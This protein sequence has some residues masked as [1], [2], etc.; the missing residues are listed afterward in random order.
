VPVD[1]THCSLALSLSEIPSNLVSGFVL[2]SL[3]GVAVICAFLVLPRHG[4]AETGGVDLGV[5]SSL[6]RGQYLQH[7][8]RILRAIR[9]INSAIL[10]ERDAGQL[11][12]RACRSLTEARGYR[13][14][15]VGLVDE[16]GRAMDLVWQVGFGEGYMAEVK[17]TWQDSPTG[18]AVRSGEP[19]VMRDIETAE[20]YRPWRSRALSQGYRSSAALPL[21]SGGRVLGALSV[22]SEIPDAFDIQEVGVLQE[23]ADHLAYALASI[24]LQDDLREAQSR[25]KVCAPAA[26]AFD[27]A[28]QAMCSTD[29]DGLILAVN[30]RMADVLG[31]GA[32]P[33]HLVGKAHLQDLALPGARDTAEQLSLLPG[34]TG[35][36]RFS[37]SGEAADGRILSLTWTGTQM[38]GADGAVTGALW[39]VEETGAAPAEGPQG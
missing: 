13:M 35:R 25:E 21:R 20:E 34:E 5:M 33:D 9:G 32:R 30:R 23:V 16:A 31:G 36:I 15:W 10:T 37:H 38:R 39:V 27:H 12:Q 22:Y 18:K 28:P 6:R 11:L 2:L 26:D 4:E 14:A 24:G 7:L 8:S 29:M 3:G 17:A 1:P 19:S